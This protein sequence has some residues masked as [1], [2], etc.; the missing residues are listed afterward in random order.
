MSSSL[1]TKIQ[2]CTCEQCRAAKNKRK[3][4]N[5]KKRIKRWLNKKRRKG[6]EGE[7]FNYYWA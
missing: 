6:E 4:R 2:V 1:S 7:V 3:N 5:L